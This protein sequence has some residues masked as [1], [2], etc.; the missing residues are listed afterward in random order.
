MKNWI[1]LVAVIFLGL[2]LFP[3]STAFTMEQLQSL[4]GEKVVLTWESNAPNQL[5]RGGAI[6]NLLQ[7]EK[8][9]KK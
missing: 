3:E 9:M 8:Q 2:V 5:Q 6:G 4:H 1:S 7:K